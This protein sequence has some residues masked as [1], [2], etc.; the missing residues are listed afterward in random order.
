MKQLACAVC[1]LTSGAGYAS[2]TPS[3]PVPVSWSLAGDWRAHDGNDAAFVG[4]QDPV[5]DWRTLRVPANWYTQGLDHQGVL[6]YRHE[7]TLPP[8]PADTM[9][10][11]QFD[12]VDYYADAW[13]NRQPLGKHEGYF[14][15]FAYDIS[16]K[17]QR[18]NKLAVRVDSPFEDPKTIWPL[19]K[20]MVKGVLNQHDT[21]PGGA[22]SPRGQDANSGGIWAPVRLH[23]S[24]GVTVDNLILRPDWQQG[25]EKPQL[26]VELVY[27]ATTAREVELVLRAR[28]ANFAGEHFTQQQ[29]VRLEAT[30]ATPQRLTFTLPMERARLWWPKGYGFPHLYRVSATFSDD[31]G[32]M[33]QIASRT[34]LR[35]IVEQPDNQGWVLNGKRIFIKGSNYIGSPWLSEMDE[36]KYRRDIQLVLDMNANAIRVHGHVAGRPLYRMAD[37]MGLMIWQDVPLQWGYN[38]SEAFAENA[39]ARAWR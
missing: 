3:V 14:Q 28:P 5:R 9:A 12:G 27:R 29:K 16:D 31:Q 8:L 30:G 25:L 37:E 10:T 20:T 15:R 13:L 24:R 17:L 39:P 19:H 7:F 2:P 34:G 33:E 38:D 32:V 18:H 21:R 26:R 23:L 11:L 6:W 4:Q 35:Q 22:W 36:K 1:L